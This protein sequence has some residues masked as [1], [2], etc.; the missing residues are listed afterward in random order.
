MKS[1]GYYKLARQSG[2]R[3]TF[4]S[5]RIAVEEAPHPTTIAIADSGRVTGHYVAAAKTGVQY[6]HDQLIL[7]GQNPP[8]VT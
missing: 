7:E 6:A 1:E 4:A 8:T 5:V 2:G 3:S